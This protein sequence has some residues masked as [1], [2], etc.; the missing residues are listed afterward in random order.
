MKRIICTALLSTVA[1]CSSADVGDDE[2]LGERGELL[3]NGAVN[4]QGFISLRNVANKTTEV[5]RR[6]DTNNYY[7]SIFIDPEGDGG[8]N[9]DGTPVQTIAQG[10]DTLTKFKNQ[11]F[12]GWA[13]GETRATYYNRGDLGLGR[14]MHCVDR[15]SD[16]TDGQI[17]CYVSNYVSA[18]KVN[19]KFS[20]L[21]FGLSTKI[22]FDNFAF[23]QPVATV[24]MV[25]RS[26]AV[27]GRDKIFFVVYDAAG[28]KADNAPLDR[29]GLA[30][31]NEFNPVTNPV[32]DPE[33]F[34]TTGVTFN[35]HIPSNC[36]NCHGGKYQNT[37]Q[38]TP[39]VSDAF[40]L[41]FDLD[42]FEYKDATGLRRADQQTQFRKL[43]Q[44][45]RNVAVKSAGATHAIAKQIDLWHGNTN[46]AAT[47]VNNFDAPGLGNNQVPPGWQSTPSPQKE[48]DIAVYKTV[49]RRSC[50]GCHMALKN[51]VDQP[52]LRF[53]TSAEFLSYINVL[54]TFITEHIMPHALQ[55]QREFWQSG[56]RHALET[57]FRDTGAPA[58][59]DALHNASPGRII[60]LDPHIIAAY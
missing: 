16:T 57:Y 46:H 39:R 14:D 31:A 55:T 26:R 47:L 53:E 41:P 23:N 27:A 25:F 24:A 29:H 56:Q 7:A 1:A 10:L 45:V 13:G 19:G 11:Y 28:N 40:F 21:S 42:Q 49:V 2:S 12:T 48:R 37:A 52:N 43:N 59:A 15:T 44:M 54:P 51:T 6:A 33:R 38:G 35:N 5:Q 8:W 50:R 18:P 3:L 60:T 34:G 58:A 32:P 9:D 17:A 20:E 22:A 4:N 36:L 30:F